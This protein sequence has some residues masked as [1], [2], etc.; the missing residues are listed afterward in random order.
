LVW[1]SFR[2]TT[3]P[4]IAIEILVPGETVIDGVRVVAETEYPFRGSAVLMVQPTEPRSFTLAVRVPEWA[5]EM[6]A[7]L[8]TGEALTAKGGE[9][10]R[11]TRVWNSGDRLNVAMD[12]AVRFANG[13][14]SY[15]GHIAVERGPLLLALEKS[16]N[17]QLPGI[18]SAALKQGG[19]RL[20]EE[21][22][23]VYSLAGVVRIGDET[24]DATLR[25]VPFAEANEYRIWI[26]LAEAK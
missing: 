4:E 17:L 20:S 10:L 11:V 26:P 1:G 16:A 18:Q 25:L 19:E 8:S 15:P 24:T 22:I 23:G 6:T 13:G 5:P 9:Y 2:A 14:R 21:R 3:D 7:R 12:L